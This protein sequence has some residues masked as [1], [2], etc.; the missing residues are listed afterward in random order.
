MRGIAAAHAYRQAKR[1]RSLRDQEADVFLR[2]NA[3][4]RA[5]QDHNDVQFTKA[6]ADNERLWITVMDL[7]RDPE[8]ALP[9]EFRA[10]VISVG[11]AMQRETAKENPDIAF[12]VGINEQVAAGLSG[13]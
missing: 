7:M 8:N 13:A 10:S 2:V 12:I 5:G 1:H 4:L 11:L 6:L 3:S 9:A